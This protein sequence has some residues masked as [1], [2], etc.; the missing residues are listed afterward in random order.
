MCF[1]R[2]QPEERTRVQWYFTADDAPPLPWS[3][4]FGSRV[5][6]LTEPQL[7]L[8]ERLKPRKWAGG[9]PPYPVSIGGLC[10]DQEQWQQGA[11]STDP[12]PERWFLSVWPKCCVAPPPAGVGGTVF[13]GE[14]A[15]V[16][17][18]PPPYPQETDCGCGCSCCDC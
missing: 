16:N 17:P 15:S 6:E 4:S 13:G 5:W 18:Y 3:S 14:V 7:P 2:D 10:G 12:R 9:K 8:G 1:Y 11:L